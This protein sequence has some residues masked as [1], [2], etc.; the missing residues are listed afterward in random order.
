VGDGEAASAVR[1][2]GALPSPSTSLIP[3]WTPMRTATPTAGNVLKNSQLFMYN[4]NTGNTLHGQ[5]ASNLTMTNGAN[6]L[7]QLL[8]VSFEWNDASVSISTR[9][10]S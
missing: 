5:N 10:T 3:V 9:V 8:G 7:E 1:C 6:T 2:S 4:Y